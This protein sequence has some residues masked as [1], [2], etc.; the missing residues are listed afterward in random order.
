M[1]QRQAETIKKATA[2]KRGSRP[3]KSRILDHLVELTGW[4]RDYAR[5]SL[6]DA[7]MINGLTE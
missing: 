7:G 2:Y 1:G 3:D 6:R 5:A 4:H